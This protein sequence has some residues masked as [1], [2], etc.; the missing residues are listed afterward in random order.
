[1]GEGVQV[2]MFNI[3]RDAQE[4]GPEVAAAERDCLRLLFRIIRADDAIPRLGWPIDYAK[5]G[6]ATVA[7]AHEGW[8]GH[9][10]KAIAHGVGTTKLE[11]LED[12]RE[13]LSDLEKE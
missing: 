12:L 5:A 9:S 4:S 8:I 6:D 11:A 2:S 1:M 13:R 3:F 7:T 10:H